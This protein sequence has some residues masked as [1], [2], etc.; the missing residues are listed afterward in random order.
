MKK[1]D[2]LFVSEGLII[3]DDS[4]GSTTLMKL[5]SELSRRHYAVGICMV[6]D[7]Y[8]QIANILGNRDILKIRNK[9]FKF[10]L[11]SF[12]PLFGKH[13]YNFFLKVLGRFG[14]I[15]LLHRYDTKKIDILFFN[16]KKWPEFEC[17]FLISNSW[18]TA[19][20]V[21]QYNRDI[22]EKFQIL[23]YGDN[24]DFAL[25]YVGENFK[26]LSNTFNFDLSFICINKYDFIKYSE[27]RPILIKDGIRSGE[28]YRA[29][30][31]AKI[32]NMI[33]IPL[34][35]H[36]EKG[37]EIAL[38]CISILIQRRSDIKII[39]FGNYAGRIPSGVSH[40]GFVSRDK[41]FT[42]YNQAT[43]FIF[44]SIAEGFGLTGLEAMACGCVTVASDNVGVREYLEPGVNGII[45]P[46]RDP[47]AL[48]SSVLFLL[49]NPDQIST[50]SQKAI[51]TA[52]EFNEV[53]MCDSFLNAV[54]ARF[55]D[56][57]GK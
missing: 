25:D 32:P 46:T 12:V 39:T 41:L 55:N 37:A 40:M 18:E 16:G 44:P 5:A 21:N 36:L 47:K 7:V 57:N 30:N 22:L 34:R 35:K 10:R 45:A 53:N 19:Y 17:K 1:F 3:S 2:F 11:L 23:Q 6:K 33:L 31:I 50:M 56:F 43:I 48:A 8:R 49:D 14:V 24:K 38:E 4:G 13:S 52:Q 20:L 15:T 29:K 9:S 27:K 28:F 42:L 54:N 51:E 26:Y